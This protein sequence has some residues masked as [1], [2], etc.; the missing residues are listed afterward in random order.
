MSDEFIKLHKSM[1]KATSNMKDALSKALDNAVTQLSQQKDFAATVK[2]FQ[3]RL[4]RD[5]ESSTLQSQSYFAKLMERTETAMELMLGKW[6]TETKNV[7]LEL[8]K[9]QNVIALTQLYTHY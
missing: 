5:L 3:H 9:L 1:A 6:K 8:N 7:G 2:G 4:L